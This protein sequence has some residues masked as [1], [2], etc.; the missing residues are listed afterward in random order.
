MEVT[1]YEDT[2]AE[3]KR[4][5]I[6]PFAC[7]SKPWLRAFQR[8]NTRELMIRDRP[9]GQPLCVDCL[10]ICPALGAPVL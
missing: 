9:R 1:V 2:E 3:R 6:D 10:C 8:L 4:L 5:R 7:K